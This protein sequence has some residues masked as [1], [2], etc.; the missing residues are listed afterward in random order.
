MHSALERAAFRVHCI[1]FPFVISPVRCLNE[2]S[3]IETEFILKRYYLAL[4]EL[5]SLVHYYYC[6]VKKIRI[7]RLVS[8]ALG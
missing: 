5:I 1:R 3:F 7:N 4:A 6:S 8:K 2:M